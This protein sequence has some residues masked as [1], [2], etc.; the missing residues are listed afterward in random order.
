MASAAY[1]GIC[2]HFSRDDLARAQ[3]RALR[4]FVGRGKEWSFKELARDAKMDVDRLHDL[5][6]RPDSAD[7]RPWTDNERLSIAIAL[8]DQG[9]D[10]LTEYDRVAGF[11]AFRL[12]DPENDRPLK[13]I[14]PE[15]AS[16][17]LELTQGAVRDGGSNVVDL[18][19]L[20]DRSAVRSAQ[21][22]ALAGTSQGELFN[23]RAA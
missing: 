13:E 14:A 16:D 8:G 21:L 15:A 2:G 22:R 23:G 7:W 20:A 4:R 18:H 3:H 19:R 5:A 6:E 10:F 9:H 12:P 17:A 1:A 11:G